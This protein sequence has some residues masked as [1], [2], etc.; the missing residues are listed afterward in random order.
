MGVQERLNLMTA[1]NI[2]PQHL[3]MRKEEEFN[4]SC[5]NHDDAITMYNHHTQRLLLNFGKLRDYMRT[6][7]KRRGQ[8]NCLYL[9]KERMSLL[10]KR[11]ASH[12]HIPTCNGNS[13]FATSG[14]HPYMQNNMPGSSRAGY[15]ADN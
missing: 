8:S 10:E 9:S 1:L 5:N 2:D 15:L 13:V 6:S 7:Q 14:Q 4:R 3:V 12:L 11:T